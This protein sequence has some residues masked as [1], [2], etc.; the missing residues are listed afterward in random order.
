MTLKFAHYRE[1]EDHGPHAVPERSIK[2]GRT[3]AYTEEN[4]VVT[5][6]VAKCGPRDNFCRKTGRVIAEGRYLKGKFDT[7]QLADGQT[8]YEAIGEAL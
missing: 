2:G 5:F 7:I 6:A 8:A 4:G 1:Y 3:V